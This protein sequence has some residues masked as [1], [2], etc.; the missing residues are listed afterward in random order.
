MEARLTEELMY[1]LFLQASKTLEGLGQGRVS[2]QPYGTPGEKVIQAV[3]AVIRELGLRKQHQYFEYFLPGN[4]D[5]LPRYVRQFLAKAQLDELVVKNQLLLSEAGIKGNSNIA[6]NPNHLY[7]IPPLSRN[8][9]GLREGYR[10]LQCSS[11]YLHPATGICPVC[12]ADNK[13]S[14]PIQKLDKDYT[15]NDFDY[16]TY[17]AEE[18]GEAFR[19]NAEELTGQT[20][21]GDRLKRQRWFQDI[22]IQGEIPQVQ[23]ID[24]L[25]VTTTM[26]AGVDIGSLLA[27]M[28]ANMPPRRFNYQQ[29]V[30]RAGRRSTGV[31][32][33]IT[34]CR[35][36][37][38]D[39]FYFQRLESITGDPPPSPYV[40]MRSYPIFLR[41][42]VKEILR[43]SFPWAKLYLEGDGVATAKKG[44]DSVHGEFGTVEDWLQYRSPIQDWLNNRENEVIIRGVL[45]ILRQETQLE[46]DNQ[47][48]IQFLR[49]ELISQIDRIVEDSSY[50]QTQ[51]S[52]RLANAGLL[53]ANN[54]LQKLALLIEI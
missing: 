47:F 40:D 37:S 18:A 8:Q 43:L 33:A 23:G 35:G 32:L 52:E 10:C 30:G 44:L 6:L 27:V 54:G 5:T 53:L 38:H 17:L 4:D 1:A 2:Y 36:R 41:V 25:S 29:R 19:M 51:L 13:D 50:S 42:L 28:M 21:K 11:F 48:I 20:D 34:F 49:Q 46:A 45:E 39:D 15:R 26:E 14:S 31:S 16:Y 22:F 12:N 7:L 3:D 9:E 24:L